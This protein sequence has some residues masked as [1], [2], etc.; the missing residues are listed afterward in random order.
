M[1][2]PPEDPSD[3]PNPDR[4]E[5]ERP[6]PPDADQVR[7]ALVAFSELIQRLEDEGRLLEAVPLLLERLGDLRNMIFDYEVRSTERLMPI[8][9]PV[10]RESR[11]VV[12][13][14]ID[15]YE[16]MLEDLD[17]D[18]WSPDGEDE[19]EEGEDEEG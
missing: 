6:A 2:P 17:D 7:R 15:R 13:E 10:E 3:R 11:R 14:A 1:T 16:E 4:P 19:D 8:E 9:D 5:G 12:R 18:D